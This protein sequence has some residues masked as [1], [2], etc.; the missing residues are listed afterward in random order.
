MGAD[1]ESALLAL[2]STSPTLNQKVRAALFAHTQLP[3]LR[4]ITDRREQGLHFIHNP[5][6]KHICAMHAVDQISQAISDEAVVKYLQAKFS[7]YNVEI[8]CKN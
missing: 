4:L 2:V 3:C 1:I 5:T 6:T 8:L 7:N